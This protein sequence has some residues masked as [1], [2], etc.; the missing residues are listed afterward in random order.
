M[1]AKTEEAKSDRLTL[2]LP[3]RT[4]SGCGSWRGNGS[5]WSLPA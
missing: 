4:W 1:A 2:R 3:D 5:S